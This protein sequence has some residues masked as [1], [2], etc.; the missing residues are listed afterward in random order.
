MSANKAKGEIKEIKVKAQK[1]ATPGKVTV[2]IDH[3]ERDS[4]VAKILR[5]RNIDVKEQQLDIADYVI[6]DRIG[7][8]RKTVSDFCSSIT[9]QRIFDQ[10]N[11]MKDSFDKTLLLIEGNPKDLFNNGLHEN[12]IRGALSSIAIDYGV[13]VLWT[14]QNPQRLGLTIHEISSLL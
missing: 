8:E 1:P 14:E 10:M 5:K 2:F 12:A 3:R 4:S 6:S 11:R 7:I 9:N 13:P